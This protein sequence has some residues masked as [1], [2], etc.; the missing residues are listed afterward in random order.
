MVT[1]P[2]LERNLEK[3][4]AA[5]YLINP[6]NI[7]KLYGLVEDKVEHLSSV[8]LSA[9]QIICLVKQHDTLLLQSLKEKCKFHLYSPFDNCVTA[10]LNLFSEAFQLG[11]EGSPGLTQDRLNNFRSVLLTNVNTFGNESGIILKNDLGDIVL[12]FFDNFRVCRVVADFWMGRRNYFKKVVA[13]AQGDVLVGAYTIG[14]E[15]Y[16]IVYDFRENRKNNKLKDLRSLVFDKSSREDADAVKGLVLHDIEIAVASDARQQSNFLLVVFE[17]GR[18]AHLALLELSSDCCTLACRRILEVPVEPDSGASLKIKKNEDESIYL[19]GSSTSL[20]GFKLQDRDIASL[21]KL[22]DI[23]ESPMMGFF[24]EKSKIFMVQSNSVSEFDFKLG[25]E[26]SGDNSSH[27]S[28]LDPTPADS[29]VR[30]KPREDSLDFSKSKQKDLR[31]T[32]E[33]NSYIGQ[34]SNDEINIVIFSNQKHYNSEADEIFAGMNKDNR[35]FDFTEEFQEHRKVADHKSQDCLGWFAQSPDT[36]KSHANPKPSDRLQAARF[37]KAIPVAREAGGQEAKHTSDPDAAPQPPLQTG[38]AKKPRIEQFEFTKTKQVESDSN[39]GALQSICF[40]HFKQFII[41]GGE[42]IN[43]MRYVSGKSKIGEKKIDLSFSRLHAINEATTLC[44]TRPAGE[45]ALL[46]QKYRVIKKYYTPATTAEGKAGLHC[47]C[48]HPAGVF[49][50]QSG[51]HSFGALD[52][53]SLEMHQIALKLNSTHPQHEYSITSGL[54][55]SNGSSIF[56][57][58][59]KRQPQLLIIHK[60]GNTYCLPSEQITDHGSPVDDQ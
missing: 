7:L 36:P 26:E 25:S 12:M 16:L 19:V 2:S 34:M 60:A 22:V 46:D 29:T 32:E 47:K 55:L 24:I 42:K 49:L 33:K 57:A 11:V 20:H 6:Q 41:F 27:R 53:R 18:K 51:Q 58:S 17:A 5:V 30:K 38:A 44:L 59:H 39:S 8:D 31:F 23:T 35:S 52:L 28:A 13:S 56:V 15:F 40:D 4:S 3:A 1:Q 9:Y 45:L 10:E 43:M 48:S 21:G 54:L 14:N 37:D 50:W